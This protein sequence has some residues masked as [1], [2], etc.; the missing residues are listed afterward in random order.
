MGSLTVQKI[1]DA[2][3]VYRIKFLECKYAAFFI[4]STNLYIVSI[5][6]CKQCQVETLK[7]G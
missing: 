7:P 3:R 6:T 2:N 4:T 1:K 5:D